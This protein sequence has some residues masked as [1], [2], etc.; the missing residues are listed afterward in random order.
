VCAVL[1]VC[2]ACA[3]GDDDGDDG[4][5]AET[6]ES[7]AE[8]EDEG[9]RTTATSAD[10]ALTLETT[11]TRAGLVSDGDVLVT[12]SGAAADDAVL[13]RDGEDVSAALADDGDVRR[14]VVDALPEGDSTIAVSAGDSRVSLVVTNHPK[15]GPVFSGPHLEPWVCTTEAAGLGPAVDDDCDAPA[16]TSFSYRATDGTTKPLPD[17]SVLPPDIEHVNTSG[18]EVPFVIRTEQ[19]VIDRG[20]YTIWVLDPAPTAPAWDPSAWNERLVYRFG[21]G[22]GTQYSQGSSFTGTADTTLLGQGYAVATNTLD[23]FQTACNP[24][25]SAEAALMTREHF[26]ESYGVPE[27]TIGD[28]GSGGA[29]QQLA[30]AHNYPGLLDALSPSVPFPDAI[31]IAPGV[32]DCGLL[33]AYY[34]GAG[35]GLTDEQRRAINGHASTGTCT[36][37]NRL[38]VGGVNPTDGCDAIGDAVY[39]PVDNRDGARCALADMNVNVLGIDPETGFARRPLDNVGVQYGLDALDSGVITVDQFLDLNERIGGYDIDG[40]IVPERA[41]MDEET[42]S[43]AYSVGAVIADGPLHDIPIVLRNLYA[44]PLGDIHTRFH[45]FSIRERLQRDGEDDPNLLLWTAA[46]TD[47]VGSLLGNT[48]G[49]N[50]PI[51]LLDRWLTEGERPDDAENRCILPD[52]TMLEG[53]WEL[54]D[55]PGPCV[56]AFPVHGDPRTAAGGPIRGDILKCALTP[57]DVQDYDVDFTDDQAARLQAVFPDGVCDWD[58]PGVGAGPTEGTWRSFGD[59]RVG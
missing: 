45:S 49:A 41:A 47:L 2:S 38:F 59:P 10:G 20:I 23:T 42:A 44:D 6:T 40:N 48:A 17:P 53:G 21:G 1:F 46:T 7:G 33:V 25:L 18:T 15:N 27:F 36:S 5:A 12:V 52:G 50:D 19:G 16:R 56:D 55:E 9:A 39:D 51:V 57:V 11:S 26:V 35:S 4:G 22:C 14:A 28:G 58:A 32:T 37:W 34:A 13:T 3:G 31:S 24:V 43:L 8:P 29:I 30:I 54:Y